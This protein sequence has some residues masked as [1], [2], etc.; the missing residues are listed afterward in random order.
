MFLNSKIVVYDEIGKVHYISSNRVKRINIKIQ[1]FKG[2]IVKV[3]IYNSFKKAEYFVLS[4]KLWIINGLKLIKEKEIL[5]EFQHKNNP[6]TDEKIY[7]KIIKRTY[8]LAD[9]Y[10]FEFGKLTI[11]NQK[12]RW[13]SCSNKNNINL[14]KKLV[15]LPDNLIDYVILHELTH[16]IEKNHS[17]KFWKKLDYYVKNSKMVNKKLN[18]YPII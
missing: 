16:T 5:S 15:H 3:P 11:R 2:V 6:I 1:L 14:N 17:P 9:K 10:N 12:T 18:Q 4:K 8:E 7:N 13:G